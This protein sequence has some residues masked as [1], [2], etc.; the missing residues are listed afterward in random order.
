LTPDLLLLGGSDASNWGTLI[1]GL[2]VCFAAGVIGGLSGFGTGILVAIL[3]TPLVGAKALIPLMAIVMLINN[4]SRVWFF[5]QGLDHRVGL[6][7]LV[8]AIPAAYVGVEIYA[9][10]DAAMLQVLIGAVIA[11]S[12]PLKYWI[13]TRRA[14][15]GLLTVSLFGMVYGVLSSV[16][17]GAGMI[18]MPALL[19]MGLAGPALIATDAFIAVGINLAKA[20]FLHKLDALTVSIGVLGIAAGLATIPGVALA[21]RISERLGIRLHTRIVEALVVIGG[22]HMTYKG[23]LQLAANP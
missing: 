16:V 1:V 4:A 11:L 13:K 18:I 15:T 21:S 14:A 10:L 12:I 2:V 17:V 7:V 6:G 3:M 23:W 19:G 22:L 5:R 8:S 20:I 9:Q